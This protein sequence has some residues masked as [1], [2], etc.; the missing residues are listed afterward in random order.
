MTTFRLQGL[1]FIHAGTYCHGDLGIIIF[2]LLPLTFS[3]MLNI[4]FEK[5]MFLQLTGNIYPFFSR[6]CEKKF[7]D[8][9][10][11]FPDQ[12]CPSSIAERYCASH[13]LLQVAQGSASSL[14]MNRCAA[15]WGG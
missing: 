14:S 3:P 9:A 5:R 11:I 7:Y 15:D 1:S 8:I 12:W 4:K 10:I 2:L 6:V 13:P